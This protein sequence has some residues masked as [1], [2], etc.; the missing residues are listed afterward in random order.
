MAA[1]LSRLA[2]QGLTE[3][4]MQISIVIP[5]LNEAEQLAGK[6]QALQ[7]LRDHCQ[8]VL[9]DGGSHDGSPLIAEPLVDK[10][11]CSPPG[12]ALQMNA[13]AEQADAEVLLFLHADSRL[14]EYAL[15]LIEQAVA[16]GCHWGRFDI[17]FDNPKPIFNVI[18]WLMNRRSRLTGISTGDQGL[19]VTRQVFSTVGGFPQIALMED[20][21]IC[22]K[23]KR[24]GKPCCLKARVVTSAR[25]W[26]Q[27]G[28]FSTIVL[29]W[30]LRLAYFFGAD[31]EDLAARYQ[32][33][34][35]WKP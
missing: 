24:L 23:L 5:V 21:A 22:R 17:A 6:L 4:F 28:I 18:A 27:H 30:R 11:I 15:N 16:E 10:V 35:Q 33:N 8:L 13:G 26:Q 19:F 9:V 7:R 25:R 20:I 14:P 1:R 2:A 12:R 34:P 32:G 29:M 31:P 3:Q